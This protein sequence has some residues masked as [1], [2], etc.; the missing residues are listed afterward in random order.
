MTTSLSPLIERWKADPHSTYNTWFLWSA[1]LKNFRSIRRGIGQVVRDIEAGTF[2]SAYRRSSLETVV[3]S[4]AE[5]RQIFR[6]ADHAFLWKPKL[7]IPDIYEHAANQR[8]FAHLLYSCDCCDTAEAFVDAIHRID[9]L[10]IKGLGSVVAN[11]LYFIHPTLISP[12]NTAIV[13]GFNAV[14]GS[15]VKLGR[16]S[17]YLSMR[18]QL[19]R[20]NESHRTQLSN[21]LGAIAALTFDIGSGRYQAPPRENDEATLAIWQ[22]ESSRVQEEPVLVQKRIAAQRESDTTH[23][24]VQGWLRDLGLALGIDVWIAANAR[25]E[26]T[27]EGGSNKAI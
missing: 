12:F 17:H 11:L 24:Q 9:T 4:I 8:A 23:T 26:C 1:R 25:A 5:Q 27:T 6:G 20:L 2:G 16:W 13:N 7:R 18:E 3:D 15:N 14:T 22:A 10:D 19:I 21:D